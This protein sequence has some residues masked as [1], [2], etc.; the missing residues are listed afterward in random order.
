[1]IERH[2]YGS[3]SPG[4]TVKIQSELPIRH[5]RTGDVIGVSQGAWVEFG[6][7]TGE[8]RANNYLTGESEMFETWQGGVIDLD[9]IA[10]D[11]GWDTDLREK[12]IRVL[13][14]QC[15][16]RPDLVWKID[17]IVPPAEKPWPN[18]DDEVG[19]QVPLLIEMAKRLGVVGKVLAYERENM[20]RPDVLEPLEAWLE[21]TGG[22]PEPEPEPVVAVRPKPAASDELPRVL[23]F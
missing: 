13:D 8:V 23:T 6:Q 19:D 12:A 15:R 22:E 4:F 18:Y 9:A 10:D 17:F 16:L 21:E 7:A 2:L 14:E 11:K 20:G 5:P 3:R 1:M